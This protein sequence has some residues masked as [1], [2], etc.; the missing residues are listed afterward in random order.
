MFGPSGLLLAQEL[1]RHERRLNQLFC[2]LG[3]APLLESMLCQDNTRLRPL[4]VETL[5][6]L[7]GGGCQHVRPSSF[8]ENC[9][10]T[11]HTHNHQ[12]NG[13]PSFF[14]VNYIMFP[15]IAIAEV[16]TNY[17]HLNSFQEGCQDGI[18]IYSRL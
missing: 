7:S 8:Y 4:V 6:M 17:R 1:F 11:L 5:S 14:H 13:A 3:G 15:N 12:N 2:K 9:S 10:K 16:D 18:L